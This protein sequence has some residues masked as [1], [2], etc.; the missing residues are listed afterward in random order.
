MSHVTIID[1]NADTI[2]QYGMCGY[3]NLKHEGYKQKIEWLKQ[4][5]NE[6]MQYKILLSE[7]GEA[8]GGIEYVPGEFTWRPVDA[9][10]YMVIH[11]IYIMSKKYKEKGHG[12]QMLTACIDDARSQGKNGVAV[13]SRK[14]TWMAKRELFIKES[15]ETADTAPPDYELLV[16]SFDG[17][18][19]VPVFLNNWQETAAKYPDGLT[20]FTSG[21]CPY[22]GKAIIEITRTAID[23]FGIQPRII[24]MKDS[25]EARNSPGGFGIFSMV[26][27]GKLVADHPVSKTRFKNIINKV[28][29]AK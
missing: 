25:S 19:P 16:K 26:Y 7:T 23:E 9:P 3:K 13:V 5:F 17:D 27:N 24:D 29:K 22:A 10:G 15:F 21:Q 1:T 28:L 14:G 11:C 12:K 4:R 20:I 18:A 2:R 8:I 6:G